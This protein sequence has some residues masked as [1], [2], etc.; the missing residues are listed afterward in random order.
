MIFIILAIWYGYKKARSTG[1]NPWLW[2]AIS[3]G[4][5]LGTQLLV[6]IGFGF[7]IGIGEEL[8]GWDESALNKYAL[9]PNI[10]AIFLSF[11][12]LLSVFRY[13]DKIPDDP[14]VFDPP[15]PPTFSGQD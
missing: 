2:A 3:G 14:P 5:F 6:G 10:A 15:P 12:A 7:L 13:L 9:L 4:V 11:A 1:R 8:W